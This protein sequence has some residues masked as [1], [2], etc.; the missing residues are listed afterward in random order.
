M[1]LRARFT[2]EYAQAA[3]VLEEA[4]AFCP[5]FQRVSQQ[6]VG[7]EASDSRDQAVCS[8]TE[9][10]SFVHGGLSNSLMNFRLE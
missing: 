5:G 10:L 7:L 6:P 2:P 1:N 3:E 8:P 9:T 4:Q